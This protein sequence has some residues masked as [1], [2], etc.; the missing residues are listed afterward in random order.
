MEGM[1]T[2]FRRGRRTQQNYQMIVKVEGVADK[3][4]AGALLNKSVLW[5][6]TSGKEIKGIITNTHGKS[7]ALRVQ[8]ERGLPGQSIGTKVSII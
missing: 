1:I 4:R 5:K 2:S 6:S 3:E 7:G 8:F